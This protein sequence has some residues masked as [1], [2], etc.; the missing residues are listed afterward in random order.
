MSKTWWA[1]GFVWGTWAVMTIMDLYWVTRYGIDVPFLDGWILVPVL[2]GDQPLNWA[3]LWHPHTAHRF[4]LPWLVLLGLYRIGHNDFSTGVQLG[5]LLMSAL[6]AAM[7]FSAR[8]LR[9]RTSAADAFF[10]LLLLH[11]GASES[12]LWTWQ[13]VFF[14]PV[15]LAG[16]VLLLIVNQGR[17]FSAPSGLVMGFCLL[18]LPFCGAM[19]VAT[20]P[21]L[22]GWLLYAGTTVWHDGRHL[23]G[24]AMSLLAIAALGLVGFYFVDFH[25]PRGAPFAPQATALT[26]W[27]YLTAGFGAIGVDYWWLWGIVYACFLIFAMLAA[28]R[29]VRKPG[30]RLRAT[31]LTA[32]LLAQLSVAV[33][34]GLGRPGQGLTLR[35]S[36]LAAPCLCGI[37]FI[38]TRYGA[39]LWKRLSPC[40][41]CLI[42]AGMVLPNTWLGLQYQRALTHN[43]AVLKSDIHSGMP[44]NV[45]A[46]R[47]SQRPFAIYPD[48]E[49]LSRFLKMAHRAGIGIFRDMVIEPEASEGHK[50]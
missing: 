36:L 23:A 50:D 35:Y 37:Y 5:P 46:A 9:G 18:L 34:V 39:G 29:A 47:Y 2:T 40:L 42:M 19:G 49:H 27:Q 14:I 26:G 21:V 6:A 17:S 15:S 20:V 1:I 25:P 12:L 44:R 24:L 28:A 43:I 8:R 33:V 16:V 45:L 22:A 10:P 41:L 7:I 32:F 30:E 3:W 4:T 38:L 13:L 11:W 48:R 31:G